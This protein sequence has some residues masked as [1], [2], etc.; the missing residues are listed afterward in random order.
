M[1]FKFRKKF[2]IKKLGI[3]LSFQQKILYQ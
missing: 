2:I 1:H 3:N